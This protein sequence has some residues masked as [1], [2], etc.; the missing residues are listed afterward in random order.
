MLREQLSSRPLVERLEHLEDRVQHVLGLVGF[1]DRLVSTR[2]C[3][4]M[5]FF[6]V[7]WTLS[8]L[9]NFQEIFRGC[10][11]RLI[12]IA[13]TREGPRDAPRTALLTS[14]C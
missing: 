12:R 13:A 2:L 5:V 6:Q 11:H 10:I 1:L 14:T 4:Q 3:G 8:S 7:W 9:D